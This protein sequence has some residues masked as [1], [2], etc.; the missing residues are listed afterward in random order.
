MSWYGDYKPYVPVAQRRAQAAREIARQ[1]KQGEKISPVHIEGR[2]ISTTFWGEAWCKHLES[3]S[4]YASRL[5]RGR[6]YVRNGSV[7]HLAIEKG[8]IH[9]FVSGSELYQVKI[10][11]G[12]LPSTTWTALKKQCVGQV[13]SLVE[14]LQ[15]KLSQGVMAIVTHRDHGLFPKPKEIQMRCSCPDYAGMCKHVAA[16]MYGVGNRLDANPELLFRLRGVNQAEL[17]EQAIPDAMT[18]PT[19]KAPRLAHADLGG[20]FDI[21]IS[22]APTP[23]PQTKPVIAKS[24][25]P[26][27]GTAAIQ[28]APKATPA[29]VSPPKPK[30][31][32][33]AAKVKPKKAA[34]KPNKVAVAARTTKAISTR[35]QPPTPV[36]TVK[37][38]ATNRVQ[39]PPEAPATRKTTEPEPAKWPA[40]RALLNPTRATSKKPKS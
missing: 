22:E 23:A 5:E 39:A 29:K 38:T 26:S 3:Y 19:G 12:A 1:F 32:T 17:I 30:A 18:Q 8:L 34:S 40:L 14:L 10:E 11:I 4:D 21:E 33:P 27:P 31:T 16:V 7:V 6:T 13:G 2:K 36:A 15:G 28:S 35:S 25:S 24:K 9:A 37:P 20:I